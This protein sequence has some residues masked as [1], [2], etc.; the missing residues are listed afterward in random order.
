MRSVAVWAAVGIEGERRTEGWVV[1]RPEKMQLTE[2][3]RGIH[4]RLLGWTL[5]GSVSRPL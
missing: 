5:G 1:C 3:E 4:V 2:L